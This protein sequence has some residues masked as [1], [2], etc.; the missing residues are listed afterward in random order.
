MKVIFISILTLSSFITLNAQDDENVFEKVGVEVSTDQRKFSEHVK[1][2]IQLPDS[3]LKNIP[4]GTYTVNVQ[5]IVDKH[6]SIGQVV[7]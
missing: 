6:G 5:F 4:P 2:K 3:V 1:R 7:S